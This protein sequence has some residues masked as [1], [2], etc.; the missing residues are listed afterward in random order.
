MSSVTLI[1]NIVVPYVGQAATCFKNRTLASSSF[2]SRT[3][4]VAV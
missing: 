4:P 3:L 2:K 1:G